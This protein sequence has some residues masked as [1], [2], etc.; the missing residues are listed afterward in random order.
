MKKFSE[1]SFGIKYLEKKKVVE[2]LIEKYLIE[3][4]E[5]SD[6]FIV[7]FLLR[8]ISEIASKG[9][10]SILIPEKI[11]EKLLKNLQEKEKRIKELSI[12]VIGNLC[13]NSKEILKLSTKMKEFQEF[14]FFLNTSDIELRI[15]FY[16]SLAFIFESKINSTEDLENFFEFIS[17]EILELTGKSILNHLMKNIISNP[18]EDQKISG[19]HFMRVTE[20]KF[21]HLTIVF[22]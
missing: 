15:S 14:L 18:F 4:Q 19:Y 2:N 16:H 20:K 8:F 3:N 12:T 17:K 21:V 1:K 22:F 6:D 11:F 9:T 5:N 13:S 10:I 7:S